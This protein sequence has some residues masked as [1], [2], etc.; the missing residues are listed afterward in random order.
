M[1]N[2]DALLEEMRKSDLARLIA[3]AAV[4]A[5]RD[6]LRELGLPDEPMRPAT[7]LLLFDLLNPERDEDELSDQQKMDLAW[8]IKERQDRQEAWAQAL[9]T[10]YRGPRGTRP[11][12]RR[13]LPA[14]ARP[15]GVLAV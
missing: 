3:R 6:P 4:R 12:V 9:R 1:S 7:A 14:W 15:P 10:G 8:K 13:L 2:A 11:A 5:G